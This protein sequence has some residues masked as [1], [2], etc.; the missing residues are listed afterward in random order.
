M[1]AKA[2]T[3]AVIGM[4]G[5]PVDVE[6]SIAQGLPSFAVV[7]LPDLAVQEARERVRAAIQS[8]DE[9]W[10]MRRVVVNLSPAH[11]RKAGSGFDLAMA[12]GVLAACGRV[13]QERLRGLC[14]IGELS[15][16]GAVRR[17]RGVLPSALAARRHGRRAVMVPAANAHEAALVE[18]VEVLPVEHLAEA[19]RFL[20]GE[21]D[22]ARPPAPVAGGAAVASDEADLADVRGQSMAK[23]ALELAAA[24]GHNML[25]TGPPGAGKTML[26]RR[27]AGILPP[28]E[29]E[30]AFEL[31]G[32]YSVA[33]LLPEDRPIVSER[34]F[35]A[36]HH[37]ISTAG[38]V[39]GGGGLPQ[40]G[41]ASLAHRG[42]LFL[43]EVAEFRRD[44]LEALRGPLEDG[45]VTIVRARWAV[46]YPCR[47]Q[48]V[49]ASNPCPCGYFDDH[50]KACECLPGAVAAYRGRLSGPMLDRI[51]LGVRVT[52][53]TR[54]ELFGAAEGE[55]SEAVR[56]R[57]AAARA[58]QAERLAGSGRT[59]NAEI[60]PRELARVCELTPSARRAS[61]AAVDRIGLSAR[62]AHRAIRVART[63]ADLA[64]HGS[65]GPEDV[66]EA[67][68][69]RFLDGPR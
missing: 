30:E 18:G 4:E 66:E 48:L 1:I 15:L 52:R 45:T 11:L 20:R 46:T 7:G 27:L 44:A 57:V 16:D 38:L 41:E 13:P 58:V 34:P 37:S 9:Q 12:V 47:I 29:P 63:V 40:P 25:M 49:A 62:G 2:G 5:H 54:E 32:M 67:L 65:V 56:E 59:S 64:G 39:G 60:P 68:W 21:S 33:G 35:R 8:S 19:V 28:L 14:L 22:L 23:R 61:E 17:V 10:P 3:V 36:P 24:G 53:L 50:V 51:D 55:S 26:A 69:Y 42:V 6:V 43:D 31:T